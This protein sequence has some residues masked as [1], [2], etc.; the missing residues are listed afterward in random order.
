M[1][2]M[3]ILI[4]IRYYTTLKGRFEFHTEKDIEGNDEQI[5]QYCRDR[6]S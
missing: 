4:I 6:R 2:A 5:A 3:I 1:I